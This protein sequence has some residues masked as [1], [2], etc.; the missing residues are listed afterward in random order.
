[1]TEELDVNFGTAV[2]LKSDF[3]TNK[4]INN[5]K[6]ILDSYIKNQEL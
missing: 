4:H 5:Y 1:M 6:L 3:S 2:K